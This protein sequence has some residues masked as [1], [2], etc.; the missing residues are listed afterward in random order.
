LDF[1]NKVDFKPNA[2]SNHFGVACEGYIN[3]Q[4]AAVPYLC[5][6]PNNVCHEARPKKFVSSLSLVPSILLV[7]LGTNLI[8][9]GIAFFTKK[10]LDFV[11]CPTDLVFIPEAP[12]F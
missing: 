12:F 3:I 2:T 4:G 6:C 9:A 8:A 5:F 11:G 7:Q 10:G 1:I